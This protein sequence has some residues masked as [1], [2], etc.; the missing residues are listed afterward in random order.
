MKYNDLERYSMKCRTICKIILKLC[1][2]LHSFFLHKN[3]LP[4]YIFPE[5][6]TFAI[7]QNPMKNDSMSY[8]TTFNQTNSSGISEHHSMSFGFLFQKLMK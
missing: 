5:F 6:Y 8:H 4:E 1:N 3:I 7:T 2:P